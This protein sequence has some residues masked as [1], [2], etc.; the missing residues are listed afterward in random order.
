VK[1]GDDAVFRR[2]WYP[3]MA[4]SRV[5]NRPHAVSLFFRDMVLWQGAGG[6][7]SALEDRCGHE[8]VRLSPG[9]VC[10]DRL[11][12]PHHHW[13]FAAD[14]RCMRIPQRPGL[15][16][17]PRA[18]ARPYLAAGRYGLAWI[19]VEQPL[20]PI[21]DVPE[22]EDPDFR[23]IHTLHERWR[24]SAFR[25]AEAALD[26]AADT[27]TAGACVIA[28][29]DETFGGRIRFRLPTGAGVIAGSLTWFAPT[30]R[31]L[32]LSY[33]SGLRRV[34][35]AAAAPLADRWITVSR[36]EARDDTETDVS[37]ADV[38]ANDLEASRQ[39]RERLQALRPDVP[40]QH[41]QD[42]ESALGDPAHLPRNTLRRILAAHGTGT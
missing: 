12:C 21:P 41:E 19:A 40:A 7:V 9:E 33:P 20:A 5:G 38:V 11:V 34:L 18:H 16:P 6:V 39:E 14:G 29:E 15:V 42:G 1:I 24:V 23:V 13:E 32:R 8:G 4:Q 25:F 3:V 30:T 37:A 28:V 22:L 31:V 26:I 27:Q 2:F 10:G 17:G 35:L 36:L